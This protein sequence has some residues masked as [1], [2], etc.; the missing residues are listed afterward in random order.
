ME[1]RRIERSRSLR[2]KQKDITI[3]KE[4]VARLDPEAAIFLFGSRTDPHKRGGDIDL[5]ILSQTLKNIDSLK[6]LKYI[7]EKMEEQKI[8]IVI[9]SDTNDP[10]IQLA[11][12]TSV[13]I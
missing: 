9:A 2:L 4:A 11:L 5:L 8:D 10:F 13:K 7:F 6:I 1:E 12:K 3:I